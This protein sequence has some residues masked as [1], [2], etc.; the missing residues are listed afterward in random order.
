MGSQPG[1]TRT[2]LA[3]ENLFLRKQLASYREGRVQPRRA[4]Y[5][6]QFALVHLARWFDR[7][8]MLTIV[9]P[10]TPLRYHQQ[11]FCLLD[12]ENPASRS[13]PESSRDF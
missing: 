3:A 8:E 9:R 1:Q 12:Q 2:V 6:M 10:A 5:P 4:S 13:G 7:R 11:A